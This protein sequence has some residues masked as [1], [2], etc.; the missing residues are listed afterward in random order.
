MLESGSKI[1]KLLLLGLALILISGA[2]GV[3]ISKTNGENDPF[4]GANRNIFKFNQ[5][6]G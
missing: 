3:S 5:L 6:S 4:E 1:Y 2:P